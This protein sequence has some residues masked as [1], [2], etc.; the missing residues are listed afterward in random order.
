MK[1]STNSIEK[2]VPGE[3]PFNK[4]AFRLSSK[5]YFLTYKGIS[6]SGERITKESLVTFLLQGNSND[7][8]LRPER[9]LICQQMYDSGQPHFHAILVYPRRKQVV[10]PDYYDYLGIHPNIQTMRNMR[11]ALDYVYKEDPSPLTNMDVVQQMRRARAKDSSSLYEFLRQQMMKDPFNFDVMRYCV[12]HN[13]DRQIYK[14]NYPKAVRLLK[15]VQQAYCNQLLTNKPGFRVIDRALI[16]EKLSPS[17]LH[18]FDSWGGYQRIVDYLN[19]M[20]TERGRRQQKSL[21]LLI[22][23]PPSI[24]KSALFWQR[25]PLPGRSS[26]V[27]HLPLYPM[28]MRDWFPDYRSDVYAGIYWNQTKLTSYSYDIILQLLDGSPVMLPAKGGG[29]KK[30]DNPLVIM[31]SNMTLQEMIRQ[32][33]HYNR[34]YQAMARQNLSVRVQN[35]VVPQG[36][37]LFLL[38]KLLLP[39]VPRP[40]L[41]GA[42]LPP[43]CSPGPSPD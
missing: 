11:A 39:V 5:C 10:S 26:V 19:V 22:T 31:T 9:Y 7:L 24:G 12:D 16:E 43:P 15:Q 32:K 41:R 25:H 18:I 20:T 2:G 23:G 28:G 38:Q 37:D 29:H 17:E 3:K 14:A 33:F 4:K 35:L 30:V 36:L 8:K 21:N 40:N 27:T 13:L 6:D 42:P 34:S 1:K